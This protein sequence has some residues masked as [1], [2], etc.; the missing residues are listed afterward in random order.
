VQQEFIR[1][2]GKLAETFKGMN[3]II[4]YGQFVFKRLELADRS[5]KS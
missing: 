3:N 5:Q 1:F 2:W 4:G